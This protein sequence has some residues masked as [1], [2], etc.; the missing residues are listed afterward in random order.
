[1]QKEFLNNEKT[2]KNTKMRKYY[3]WEN[4]WGQFCL[5]EEQQAIVQLYLPGEKMP[6]EEGCRPDALLLDG[7][8]QVE[9]YLRGER[10]EFSVPL[11]PRGTIF[12][13]QVWQELL[14]IPYGETRSYQHCAVKLGR[15]G[16]CRAVGMACNRNPL[17]LFIP[18]H[19]V[20]AKNGA[21]QGF[22]AGLDMKIKLLQL[23]Q[24]QP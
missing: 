6:A 11:A 5:V 24:N 17:P 13:L 20:L 4:S 21:L 16:A 3:F 9:E 22:R 1:M 19:R 15:P 2:R 10:R 7:V 14:R 18:C 12:Q 23:E 8:R